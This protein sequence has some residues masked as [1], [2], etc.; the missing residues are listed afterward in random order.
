VVG[1]EDYLKGVVPAE[2]PSSWHAEALKSQAVAARSYA[3]SHRATAK[4]YD[5]YSDTRS[6][7][8]AGIAVE[9]PT[10]SAA[11]DATAGQVLLY[12]GKIAD[13]LFSS[14]SGGRTAA[15][16]EAF[17]GSRPVPYL[18]SVAD[19]YD[20]SPY[21]N[22]GPVGVSG[23]DV[24]KALNL[25]GP[26]LDLTPTLGPSKRLVTASLRLPVGSIVV[27]GSQLRSAL[28]LRSTWLTTSLLSLTPPAAPVAYGQ[29][30]TIAGVVRGLA[31]VPVL[32]Q[33]S[34]SVFWSP[35]PPVEP[36]AD[37]S[38][39]IVTRLQ[40]TTDYRLGAGTIRGTPLRI[41]VAPVVRLAGGGRGTVRPAAAGTV[42]IQVQQGTW[43]KLT[44]ATV[45][46]SGAFDAGALPSGTYRARYAPGGGLAAGVSPPL[47]IP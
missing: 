22:W 16:A 47:V 5:L 6:Q 8:Y 14:S 33:R 39:T 43:R 42:D 12:N 45:D 36:A 26:V 38:F 9:K 34:G 25:K 10:T 44:T 37:G 28:G 20:F 29:T 4:P 19:P 13:T 7:V 30:A 18:V 17:A 21:K 46:A 35:G 27:S 41:A 1:L 31:S 23:A 3:L 2:M 15:N 24:A 11:I 40:R 32:E